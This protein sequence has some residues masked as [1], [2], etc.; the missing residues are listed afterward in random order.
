M[1]AP[2]TGI[3]FLVHCTLLYG[4]S[5]EPDNLSLQVVDLVSDVG[6]G[7]SKAAAILFRLRRLSV[8]LRRRLTH[9]R[10]LTTV[11]GQVSKT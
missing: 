5:G 3:M 1:S 4:S 6:H 9:F 11:S 8:L 7:R 10:Q 2:D